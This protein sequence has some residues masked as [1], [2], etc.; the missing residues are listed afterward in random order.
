MAE[1]AFTDMGIVKVR[2]IINWN[3]LEKK[4][5]ALQYTYLFILLKKYKKMEKYKLISRNIAIAANLNN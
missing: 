3:F 2:D 5:K 1:L 4:R